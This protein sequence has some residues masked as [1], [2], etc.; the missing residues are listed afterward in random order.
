MNLI[1]IRTAAR[2]FLIAPD[3]KFIF[4][5]VQVP[6]GEQP[7]GG[8]RGTPE[9]AVAGGAGSMLGPVGEHSEASAAPSH[10]STVEPTSS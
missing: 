7:T 3:G 9:S 5:V 1:R 6:E 4:A 10:R 8:I 2:E